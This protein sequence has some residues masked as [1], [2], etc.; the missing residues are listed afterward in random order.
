MKAKS[1]RTKLIGLMGA[2]ILVSLT[3]FTVMTMLELRSIRAG[4]EA[5]AKTLAES[6]I[7]KID[8]NLFERYG[9]V[10]AFSLSEPARSG[11][12]ARITAFMSD[13]MAAYAPIYDVMLVVNAA[14]R[15][16][17]VNTVDKDGKDAPYAALIGQDLSAAAWFKE[18]ISGKVQPGSAFV[19]DPQ[20][21]TAIA[22]VVGKDLYYMNFTAPIRDRNT[23]AILGVWSNRASWKDVVEGITAEELKKVRTEENKDIFAFLTTSSGTFIVHPDSAKVHKNQLS[24]FS[25]RS[26]EILKSTQVSA[27]EVSENY[28]SGKAYEAVT[29]SK[30]YSIYPGKGWFAGVQVSGTE[31]ALTYTWQLIILACLAFAGMMALAWGVIQNI[32]NR[33]DKVVGDLTAEATQVKS[34]A[35]QISGGAKNLAHASTVQASAIQETASAVEETNAMVKKSAD[36]AMRSRTVSK[37]SHAAASKGK[38]SVEE[39]MQAIEDINTSNEAIMRQIE[40]SNH[41]IGEIVKVITEIG[42]KTKVINEIVFQTKLLSFNASVE[43]ARAGEHGKGFAV[44]AEEVGNLAQMSGNAAKEIADMLNG[45]ISRVEG[46]V[47]NTKTQVER[48]VADGKSKVQSG[49]IVAKQCAEILEDV[50][51]NVSEVNDMIDEISTAAQEQSQGVSEIT[52]AINQLDESTHNNASISQESSKA[53]EQLT[54]QAE[55]MMGVVWTLQEIVQGEGEPRSHR[56]ASVQTPRPPAPPVSSGKAR[57]DWKTFDKSRSQERPK[58]GVPGTSLTGQSQFLSKK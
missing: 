14:G 15:V 28:F 3:M 33:I 12:P 52:K 56:V 16:I 49:T 10:Q 34:A 46:I 9:D 57:I 39:M 7:D 45:S 5:M 19:E 29:S 50:V 6:Y 21:D 11:S 2:L 53:A 41:Q 36:N 17:A 25:S 31:K 1:L 47:S 13:M 40:D 37:E 43:A 27:H 4:K 20:L 24:D 8:R 26:S 58:S 23:G 44:V 54:G 42:S 38:Q 32:S 22:K 48:L 18:A 55:H 35:S 30:G 51:R